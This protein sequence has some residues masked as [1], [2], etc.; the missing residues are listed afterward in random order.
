LDDDW[1]IPAFVA[2]HGGWQSSSNDNP[3]IL[4][5][6]LRITVYTEFNGWKFCVA[7]NTNAKPYFSDSYHLESEARREAIALVLRIKPIHKTRKEIRRLEGIDSWV[8][9][10]REHEQT[11]ATLPEEVVG[12][13][14]SEHV[15]VAMLR[16]LEGRMAKMERWSTAGAE[17]MAEYGM[18]EETRAFICQTEA[19][20]TM[21]AY[22]RKRIA[23]IK[24]AP[25]SRKR[26]S[27]LP[28]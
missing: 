21:V 28:D 22:V 26:K 8:S 19:F 24:A 25:R 23:E 11:L 20:A 2:E 12:L 9:H 16:K 7:K 18:P 14:H 3:M 1:R 15:T 4:A 17:N 5:G 13:A 6:N 27:K 10:L